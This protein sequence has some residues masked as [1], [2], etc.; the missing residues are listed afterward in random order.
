MD[1]SLFFESLTSLLRVST[2][3]FWLEITFRARRIMASADLIC[4]VIALI[5][6]LSF[7]ISIFLAARVLGGDGCGE[8]PREDSEEAGPVRNFL[9]G[10]EAGLA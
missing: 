3:S 4:S 1:F 10:A 6:T 9:T 8:G 7:I 2:K 5:L